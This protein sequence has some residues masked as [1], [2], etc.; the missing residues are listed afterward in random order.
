LLGG[1]EEKHWKFDSRQPV[2]C[3]VWLW[4]YRNDFIASIPV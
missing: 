1:A 4:S 3:T 2:P